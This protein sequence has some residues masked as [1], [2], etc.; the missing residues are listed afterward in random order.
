MRIVCEQSLAPP[1]SRQRY[2]I[3]E[4]KGLGHPDTICDA[5]MDAVSVALCQEYERVAGRVL[6]HNLDKSLLIAGQVQKFCGGGQVIRP[7]ELVMGD[8]A[9]DQFGTTPIPVQE[10]AIA[11]AKQ[12]FRDHLPHVD[13][14]QHIRFRPVMAPGSAELTDIFSRGGGVL[15]A[16][17][18]SGAVG[19]SPYTPLER[20]VL[21]LEAY[22]NGPSFK[23]EFPDTGQDVK[24]MATRIDARVEVIVAMPFL[25][26]LLSDIASYFA[27]KRQAEALIRDF[28]HHAMRCDEMH[29]TLN[30]LDREDRGEG[31]VYLS[32]TGTSAEDAD[33]GQVGRGNRVSGVIAFHRPAGAEAA[34]G[35]N[36]VSHVGKICNVLAHQ[37]AQEILAATDGVE[38]V[39]LWILNQIGQPIDSPT[40]VHVQITPIDSSLSPSIQRLVED[41][42]EE[43]FARIREF[44]HALAHGRYPVC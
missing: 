23:T 5:V 37:L 16:N 4:R 41:L 11:T 6:H 25:A 29:L 10:I 33:S 18:T 38:A 19:H 27:R 3:V 30:S 12:W 39:S 14:E 1:L 40:L 15:V 8:R 32:L 24:I 36:P 44:C 31:G 28:L 26:P 22:L 20:L 21:D 42:I 35:K 17:D 9:T 43:R 7:M 13:P 34:A 2:E